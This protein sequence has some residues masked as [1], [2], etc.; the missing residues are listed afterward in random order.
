VSKWSGSNTAFHKSSVNAEKYSSLPHTIFSPDG[1]LYNVERNARSVS[2]PNDISSNLVIAMKFGSGDEEAVIM[3]STSH[4]SPHLQRRS[5][6]R[7][8]KDVDASNNRN[9]GKEE[10]K[11]ESETKSLGID[12][13]WSYPHHANDQKLSANAYMPIS[14]L[15]SNVLIGTGGTATDSMALHKKI[16]QVALALYNENDNMR[17]TH[18]IQGTILSSILAKKLAG[19][20]QVST[21]SSA[22]ER[23]FA[24]AAIVVGPDYDENS[25]N[26]MLNQSIWR[27]DPTGQFYN[28]RVAAV[29]RGA[30]TAEAVVM[31][32]VAQCEEDGSSGETTGI[33]V[34]DLVSRISP[35]D[36][37][38][39]FSSLSFDDAVT[40]GC[41]CIAKA[42]N[43]PALPNGI[44]ADTFRDL[45][46][47]GILLRSNKS[48]RREKIHPLILQNALVGR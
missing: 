40:L 4:F 26:P 45:G 3:L 9:G 32:S 43:L 48:Y 24:S 29:G 2:D 20:A 27:C 44:S 30:G 33:E 38:D 28:C 35:S 16:K 17:S 37:D 22:S 8:K 12:R 34:E 41:K 21:Q 15:P 36:V 47:H 6:S 14:V 5:F 31:A 7:D 19:S 39:Y 46:I 18:R 25:A 23:M 10:E 1:R 42:L 13:L 11:D